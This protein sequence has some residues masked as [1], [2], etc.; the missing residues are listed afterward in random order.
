[1]NAKARFL[2]LAPALFLGATAA[3]AGSGV[4]M[5]EP[6]EI[7]QASEV[8]DLLS[9]GATAMRRPKMRGISLDPAFS[10]DD[11]LKKGLDKVAAP[12]DTAIGLRVE[13]A[14]NSAA[15]APQYAV[16]LDA[17]AEG[18]KMTDGLAVVV[19]G[20]T[21]ARGPEAYNQDLSV[22]RALAVKQYLVSN[23]GIGDTQLIV[24]GFGESTPINEANPYASGN[25]RVQ[26]R[27]AP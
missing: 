13:F 14:F 9:G 7:P 20:H 6:G 19:E 3:Q 2:W 26:F 16:Q 18:I 23:H 5:Y 25:R 12:Q 10:Q 11:K 8:A 17:V 24:K 4:R 21:D 27:A 22:K 1:M 15:I